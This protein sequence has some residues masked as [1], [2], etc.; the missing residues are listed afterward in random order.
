MKCAW[1]VHS[2]SP[3]IQCV[4]PAR[5]MPSGLCMPIDLAITEANI[6]QLDAIRRVGS[7]REKSGPSCVY[8]YGDFRTCICPS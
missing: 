3:S 4:T 7:L 8:N 5:A 6:S 1:H 2:Y